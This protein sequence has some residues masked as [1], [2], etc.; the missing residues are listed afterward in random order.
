MINTNNVQ[1]TLINNLIALRKSSGLTQIELGDKINYSDKTI[2]KWEKGDSCPSIEAICKIANFYDITVDELLSEGIN[3]EQRSVE[4]KQR[5]YSKLIISLLAV[6]AVWFIASM[7]FVSRFLSHTPGAW[8][9]FIHAIPVSF[10]VMLV[11]NSMWGNRR[12]NYIIISGMV[13]SVL[14]SVFLSMLHDA[15]VMWII[16]LI[17]IPIQVAIILWSQMT[18]KRKSSKKGLS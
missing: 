13:W 14:T 1:E 15:S 17:G 5:R 8:L 10:A 6:I 2:S 11:F 3:N 12:L 4:V 9:I 7:V 16:Y 18:R